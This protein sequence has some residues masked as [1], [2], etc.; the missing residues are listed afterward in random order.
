MNVRSLARGEW[1]IYRKAKHSPS[2]GPRAQEVTPSPHGEFYSYVVDK[3]WVVERVLDEGQL[4]LRTR[5]GKQHLVSADDPN[6]RRARWWERWVF[7]RRFQAVEREL[8]AAE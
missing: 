7:R 1:V 8:H 4:Q 3:F 2:P 6:L 5:R